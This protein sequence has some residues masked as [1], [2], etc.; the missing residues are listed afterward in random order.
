MTW[1]SVGLEP[2]PSRVGVPWWA[3]ARANHRICTLGSR[4]LKV[5]EDED[6]T[7][8]AEGSWLLGG[9]LKHARSWVAGAS[10]ARATNTDTVPWAL[11]RGFGCPLLLCNCEKAWFT[12]ILSSAPAGP[13]APAEG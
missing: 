2:T 10:L 13:G 12:L 7:E 1:L 9:P 5:G 3:S 4:R 11:G 6:F 8:L